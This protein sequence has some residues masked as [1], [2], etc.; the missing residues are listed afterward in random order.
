MKTTLIS[1]RALSALALG[2]LLPLSAPAVV[3]DADFS[4]LKAMV[5]KLNDQVQSLQQTNAFVQQQHQSDQAQIQQLQEK[6][7]ATQL[8]AADAEQKSTAAAAAQMQPLPRV[9]LD[10]ATVNHNF[11]ILGDAE[12]QYAKTH[13]S[14]GA[15]MLADFAPIFLYRGGDNILFEAGFD[16][17]MQNNATNSP[18]YTTTVNL[19]F[20]QLDYLMSDY[21]M[22]CAGNLVL[23]LGTY[24]ER[25]A[26]WLNKFPDSPLARDLLP[27]TGVGAE[28]RG[29][30]PFGSS[31]Q[32]FNYSIYGVN[33]PGSADGT[34]N[35]GALDLGGNVGL[36]S[37]NMVANLHGG[38]S[39]GGRLGV[40]LPFKPHCDLE[41][42]LSGQ[43]GTWDNA[44]KHYWSAGVLDAAL[45]LGPN[46]E[47]KGEYIQT[48]YGSDDFGYVRPQGWYVQA[49]YKLSGLNLEWPGINNVE[50]LGRYDAMRDGLGVTT[51]RVSAGLIYYFT[52]A[53]LFEGDYEFIHC[54]DPTQPDSQAIL[55]LSYGF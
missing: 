3:S 13:G 23:P 35:S 19:S 28:L 2:L 33:G 38:A 24:S 8:T 37:D 17:V 34:G 14:H 48:A 32:S 18:G 26:G 47:A 55:Q 21:A 36:R 7:A 25:S 45:H 4:A 30:I 42:G 54:T 22:L 10:E 49:G 16:F 15:F 40:F 41:L 12:F 27:G 46:F 39:A 6:L 43:S 29:A 11:Q 5:D 50:L 20:A 44:D 1:R 9:P 51:E 52:T 53:L 31:G